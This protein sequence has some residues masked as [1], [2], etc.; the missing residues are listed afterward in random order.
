MRVSMIRNAVPDDH[1]GVQISTEHPHVLF[2][3]SG[4]CDWL[5]PIKRHCYHMQCANFTVRTSVPRA[6][7]LFV[8]L[9]LTHWDILK[10]T[11]FTTSL[12]R[13]CT[14]AVNSVSDLLIIARQCI[15]KAETNNF[16]RLPVHNWNAL[17]KNASIDASAGSE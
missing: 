5:L 3:T 1:C 12:N 7:C 9:T 8:T 13:P 10:C 4:S 14:T 16:A 17:I 6:R 2:V 15:Y 11:I